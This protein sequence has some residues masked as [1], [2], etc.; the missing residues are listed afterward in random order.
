MHCSKH[1][2]PGRTFEMRPM[3]NSLHSMRSSYL[4]A[5]SPSDQPST[6]IISHACRRV[7]ETETGEPYNLQP[8]PTPPLPG[9]VVE[10]VMFETP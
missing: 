8:S 5:I 1:Q 9:Y 4:F 10:S 6:S 2:S 7:A 3:V